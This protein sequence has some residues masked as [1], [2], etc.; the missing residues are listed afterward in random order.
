MIFQRGWYHSYCKGYRLCRRP[1]L[2]F[3]QVYRLAWSI[4]LDRLLRMM[5]LVMWWWFSR[6]SEIFVCAFSSQIGLEFVS[7]NCHVTWKQ[8]LSRPRNRHQPKQLSTVQG[9]LLITSTCKQPSGDCLWRG[10]RPG[11]GRSLSG[12]LGCLDMN[13]WRFSWAFLESHDLYHGRSPYMQ[14]IL[15]ILAKITVLTI[16]T[17]FIILTT[18]LSGWH[19][20]RMILMGSLGIQWLRVGSHS[21]IPYIHTVLTILTYIWEKSHMVWYGMVGMVWYGV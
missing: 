4:K 8:G 2:D 11:A 7:T 12:F 1:L 18:C 15:T 13:S 17:K 9:L 3:V 20:W 16:L 10:Q 5:S 21:C 6:S 19:W 14:T